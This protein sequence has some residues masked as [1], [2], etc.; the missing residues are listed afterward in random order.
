MKRKVWILLLVQHLLPQR[1]SQSREP[2]RKALAYE[3]W[4]I[5]VTRRGRCR[6]ADKLSVLSEPRHARRIRNYYR[7]AETSS[8]FIARGYLRSNAQNRHRF[9]H[10]PNNN[11]VIRHFRYCV[12]LP[13]GVQAGFFKENVEKPVLVRTRFLWF[14]GH[15]TQTLALRQASGNLPAFFFQF[16]STIK[17]CKR[18]YFS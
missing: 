16:S 17:S 13:S 7:D 12:A 11:Q 2:N 10:L 1:N 14:K 15:N 6:L 4:N 9:H 3:P 5:S 8:V 18:I